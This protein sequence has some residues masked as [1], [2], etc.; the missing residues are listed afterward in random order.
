[1]ND[2][3]TMDLQATFD[4]SQVEQITDHDDPNRVYHIMLV[5]DET[6]V[7]LDVQER[8]ESLGYQM[9]AHAT[10]GEEAIRYAIELDLDLILMDVKLRGQLDGIE[11]AA[12][13]RM[14]KDIPIIYLTAFADENTLKRASLTEA[15][16]YMIKPFEDRE[17]Y[18]TIEMALYKYKIEKKLR[19]SEE[20]Y[21]L[22]TRATHDGIWDWDLQK[23]EIYYS[24]RWANMLGL[25]DQQI[26]CMLGEWL[27]R[28][29]PEDYPKTKQA[30]FA[31]LEGTTPTLECEYRILHQDGGYRWMLCRGLALLD[32]N[33]KPYRMA[34]SQSDISNRKR[35]EQELFH[36]ALYDELTGLPNR[37]LFLDRMNIILEHTKRTNNRLSALLFLDLDNFKIIN[38]SYG[39]ICGDELLIA[40]GQR[41]EECVRPGDTVARF[42]GDEFAILVDT[43]DEQAIATNIAKRIHNELTHPFFINNK[44]III[45]ASIGIVFL[46]T[47]YRSSEDL[48]RD[49]DTA[50]YSAK[51]RG[52]ARYE[53][54]NYKMREQT[55]HRVD[56]EIELRRALENH[57]F[58]LYYQPIYTATGI[59]LVGFEA[60]IRWQHPTRGLI[61]PGEFI[62]IAEETKL[63]VPLGDW[64]LHEA[65]A[66]A[67]A[68]NAATLKPLKM[69]V[70]ISRLQ[71]QDDHFVQNIQSALSKHGLEPHLLEL[72]IT[73]SVA[74]ENVEQTFQ[75]LKQLQK[76]GVSVAIDDFGCGYSSLDHLKR[77]PAN[78]LKIDRSFI[79]D[80]KENDLA[81]VTAMISMAHQLRL[82]VNGEG[83]ETENQLA[84]L[85]DL[86]C[87]EVQGYYLGKP[88]PQDLVWGIL[89]ESVSNNK[90]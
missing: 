16:G 25:Q 57:E 89:S 51:N 5:E 82:K 50:M 80:L 33:K 76:I 75:H 42:G 24:P 4:N 56:R 62:H 53:I 18:S 83:V 32:S 79:N 9:A 59:Q 40:I 84:I 70:N 22:A 68:W 65:C 31:H 86:E 81:I 26:S 87:D 35:I 54:F 14:S 71:L 39:H 10:T 44:E 77:F 15:Y 8:L 12:Q 66:Q 28:V 37:A 55:L 41:L 72:E 85:S 23:N 19:I 30:I 38:D 60:L 58:S 88:V 7:A 17:L 34:G 13:I 78:I 90:A 63:I 67:Q 74:M 27:D 21:A 52:R 6:I 49:V 69:S 73:E 48:L 20:R 36:K 3:G 64:V 2:G 43:V 61:L 47:N 29:H 1:M 45:S 11:T 46:G